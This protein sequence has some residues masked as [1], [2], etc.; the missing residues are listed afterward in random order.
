VGEA[1]LALRTA[2]LARRRRQQD[3]RREAARLALEHARACLA[4]TQARGADATGRELADDRYAVQAADAACRALEADAGLDEQELEVARQTLDARRRR[5]ARTQAAAEAR[6]IRAPIEGRLMRH[7][8]YVGEVVRPDTLLFEIFGGT[9]LILKL[10]VPERY[11]TRVTAGQSVRARFRSD[12]AFWS[13]GAVGRVLAVRDVI[14][15]DGPQAYRVVTCS[16]DP[17]DRPPPPPG[18]T[19]DAQIHIGRSSFWA[20]LFG[21]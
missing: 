13:P 5:V 20:S 18:T 17:V 6:A 12:R 14:Q 16:L 7:T 3:A 1:E 19:A 9:N 2:E 10:R 8:F 15:T 4:L 11:A 21:L